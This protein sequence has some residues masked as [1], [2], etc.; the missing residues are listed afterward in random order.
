VSG[1]GSTDP[2]GDSLAYFWT[3]S[4][5]TFDD[6]NVVAP[7]LIAPLGP[8][9]IGL[10]VS[11]GIGTSGID[12]ATITVVDT[13][14][15]ALTG[16]P[17]M[18]VVACSASG[19]AV[20]PEPDVQDVC[21]D[22]AT[23]QVGGAVIATTA[24][25]LPVPIALSPD[26]EAVLPPGI[27]TVRWTATDPAGNSASKE[28]QVEVESC[29]PMFGRQRDHS[30]RSSLVGPGTNARRFTFS[31]GFDIKSS[32]AV[33]TDGTVYF[34]SDDNKVY[35]VNPDGSLKWSRATGGDVQSSPAV[36]VGG[37]IWVG[38][39]DDKLYAL[40]PDD[41]SVMC[42]RSLGGLDVES[43]PAVAVD[44]TVYAGAEDNRLYAVNSNGCTIKW[45]V[46]TGGDVDSSPAIGPNGDVYFGSDDNKVYARR[47]DGSAKWIH[48]TNDDVNS[49]P[50]LS[51]DGNVVFI[52]S[53]DNRVR[54]L[55]ADTGALLWSRTL[56]GT[57]R[58]RPSIG[59]TGTVYV[60][61]LDGRL[62]ALNPADGGIL[63]S[64]QLGTDVASSPAVGADGV[65]YV[66][67]D[68]DRVYAVNG[69]TGVIVWSFE[70]GADVKSSP[71]IGLDGVLFVGSEDDR[72]YAFGPA[73]TLPF[74][75]QTSFNL[76]EPT[77][78]TPAEPASLPPTSGGNCQ[79]S[80][81]FSNLGG[82]SGAGLLLALAFA[83]R[84]VSARRQ[85]RKKVGRARNV[86]H[87]S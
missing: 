10:Q 17:A 55:R 75:G 28:V 41:G 51:G 36:G 44:G 61:A 14:P 30:G 15:P 69:T 31:A 86:S 33:A 16:A 32:P 13:T 21:S 82:R 65:V 63:W 34:G 53:D 23:V 58:T 64:R 45:S 43:S 57:V 70:T 79:I 46:T 26:G 9:Q 54:A 11:D 85:H 77:S 48:T 71:A 78:R 40:D 81:P 19:T 76:S 29:W 39:D 18:T 3:G 49:S 27:H 67:S 59:P 12:T 73:P 4:G 62:Y 8:S 50:T 1:A 84:R 52:G 60:S 56:G 83:L 24:P 68:D 72:L 87:R 66:G 5:V 35:A 42:S 37:V 7:E 6:A 47:P 25:N 2:D 38:S 80:P 22:P 74:A 20:I